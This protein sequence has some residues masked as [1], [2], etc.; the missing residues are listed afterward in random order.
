MTGSAPAVPVARA[1]GRPRDPEA[2]RAILEATIE[3]L[4]EDGFGGLSIEAVAARAG[5]GKTTVYRRWPSKI[6]LVVDALTHLK[7]P[8]T[9]VIPA[10]TMSTRDALVRVMSEVVRAHE[11]VPTT[12]ILAGLVDA[13]SRDTELAGAVRRAT[14]REPPS[15]RVRHHRARDRAWGDPSRCRRRGDRRPPRR[16]DSDADAPHRA[17]RHDAAGPSDRHDGARWSRSLAT[18]TDAIARPVHPPLQ[19]NLARGGTFGPEESQFG[20]IDISAR[21]ASE[22]TRFS[23]S[24]SAAAWK[25]DMSSYGRATSMAPSR[26]LRIICAVSAGDPANRRA[27]VPTPA[28]ARRRTRPRSRRRTR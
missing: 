16:S 10:H 19:R 22:P 12:Q 14:G 18:P 6:P 3:L 13:M 17:A 2:D 5:V 4:A 8:S 28:S 21:P 7:N 9:V 27:V 1:V 26:P 24:R 23:R 11:I 25:R 15:R 20:L